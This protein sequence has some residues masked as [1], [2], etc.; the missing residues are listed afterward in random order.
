MPWKTETVMDQRIEFILAAKSEDQPL[1]G[2]CDRFGISRVTGYK[3]LRR[4]ERSSSLL[5]LRKI[6]RRPHRSPN[7]TGI[8]LETRVL[9]IRDEKGWGAEK[10]EQ[11]LKRE[12]RTDQGRSDS[13]ASSVMSWRRWISRENICFREEASVIRYRL[14]MIAVVIC[15]GCGLWRA[16]AEKVFMKV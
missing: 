13:P 3:W 12:E 1:S 10:I 5:G 7:R 15:L 4:Y 14:S 9:E 2:I 16:Q 11:I 8:E 6:S